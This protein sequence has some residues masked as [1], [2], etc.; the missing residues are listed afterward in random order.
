[1]LAQHTISHWAF[2][3]SA[4]LEQLGDEARERVLANMLTGETTMCFGMSEPDAGSDA[5]ALR[6]TADA[7]P[8]GGWR[9]NGRKIWTSNAATADWIIVLAITDKERAAQR[10]GGI[11]AFMVPMS[12]PG[13]RVERVIRF[14]GEAGGIETETTFDDVDIEPWQLVGEIDEGFRIGMKGVSLG[15]IFNCA[16]SVGLGRWALEMATEYVQQR[17]TFGRPISDYQ[18]VTFPLAESAGEILGAHL[19]ALNAATLLD[20]GSRA[21]KELSMAKLF[22]VRAGARAVDRAMQAHGAMGFTNDLGLVD[23]YKSLRNVNVADGTNEILMRTIW[24][25]MQAGDLDL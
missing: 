16:R 1:M 21:E 9:L 12:A 3:P 7:L 22:A 8:G 18:G 11:S 5:A 25:R 10:R 13:V 4:V 24:K 20:A 19:M 15:R 2:G 14:W 17:R 23:A 6:S